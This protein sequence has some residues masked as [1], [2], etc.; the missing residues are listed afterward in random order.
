MTF[1]LKSGLFWSF[2]ILKVSIAVGIV[3]PRN[4]CVRWCL[5]QLFN[6]LIFLVLIALYIN[7]CG[8]NINNKRC[9]SFC[10]F[11]CLFD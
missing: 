6:T 4:P 8:Q 10:S 5:P 7:R 1:T 2:N 9:V 11:T 3:N